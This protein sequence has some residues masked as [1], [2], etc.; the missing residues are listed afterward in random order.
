MS[1]KKIGSLG[2]PNISIVLIIIIVIQTPYD[3]LNSV[4]PTAKR[5]VEQ[6]KTINKL[7][8]SDQFS[9]NFAG[10]VRFYK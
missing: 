10:S 1:G 4:R 5:N 9:I 7:I 2:L 8:S 6:A 3:P